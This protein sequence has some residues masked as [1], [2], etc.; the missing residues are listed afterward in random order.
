MKLSM[1]DAEYRLV[2]AINYSNLK[3]MRKSP[4]HYR[5]AVD[6]G[7]DP[8]LAQKLAMFRAVHTLVLEPFQFTEEYVVYDGRRDKRTKAYQ[9][10]LS[11]HMGK[12]VLNVA[13]HEQALA[14]AEAVTDHSWVSELL[15]DDNTETEVPMVWDDLIAGPCKGK[16]DILH[17]SQEKGLIV[18]DLKTFNTTD[19][20]QI[21][22]IGSQNGWPLQFAHYLHGAAHHFGVSLD[23]VPYRAIS[24]VVEGD[25]PHDVTVAEWDECSIDAAMVEHRRLLDRVAECTEKQTWP[26]RADMQTIATPSFLL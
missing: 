1:T 13:E 7:P 24:I 6:A 17:W 23:K 8:S 9:Q 19:G 5:H 26:G 14:I 2:P 18:A 25:D 16:A 3:H 22:R 12:T 21:A 11:E 4:L 15:C 10:F 20:K